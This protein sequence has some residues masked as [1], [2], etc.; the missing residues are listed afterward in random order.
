MTSIEVILPLQPPVEFSDKSNRPAHESF[1]TVAGRFLCVKAHDEWSAQL[2]ESYFSGWHVASCATPK[3]RKPDA[4]IAVR[5]NSGP[6]APPVEFT[7]F[8]V[9]LGGRCHTDGRTYYFEIQDSMVRV[10]A[11]SPPLVEVWIGGSPS[12]RETSALARIVFNAVMA[13]LRRCGLFELHGGGVVDPTSGVGA[14]FIGP[15]GSGKSTLTMQ[16]AASGWQYLSDDTLL[17][18]GAEPGVEAWA[19]RRVFAVTEPTIAASRLSR[20]E[21]VAT[22]P[23]PFD[24]LKRRFEPQELFPG[25]FVKACAPRALI[26]PAVTHEPATHV[27]R[28]SQSSTMTR[29][30]KMCPW[31]CYDRPVAREHLELLSRLAR[32]SV[33]FDLFAGRDLMG[34]AERTSTLIASLMKGETG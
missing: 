24:P 6:P 31:S 32:Q 5:F 30:L 14:L 7:S 3:G 34:D 16:L 11:K 1:Y 21:S 23:V 18:C 12:A 29:L 22:S 26:F 27:E 17:L 13:A 10:V 8:D 15:S 2:F 9:A 20:L 19:W 25:G 28:L 33:A 4:T